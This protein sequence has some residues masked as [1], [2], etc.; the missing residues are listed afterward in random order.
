MSTPSLPDMSKLSNSALDFIDDVRF[1]ELLSKKSDAGRIR[2]I[3][4]KSKAKQALNLDEAAA[5]LNAD[6]PELVE[7]IYDTARQLKK[8][9]YGNRIVLFAPFYV[10]NLC[11]NDCQYC[12]FR[13]S[14]AEQIRH[15]LTVEELHEQVSRML[16]MGQKR[17]IAVFGEHR[18]Y[19]AQYIADTVREIYSV[20]Y[21]SPKT[22]SISSLRRVNINA[23][24]LDHG[25]YKIVREA[26]I[27]TYQVFQE[28][29]HKPTYRKMHPA[30]TRKSDFMWRLD[31]PARAIE[32][33]CDDVGLGALFGLASW[34]F[35]ALSLVAHAIHLMSNYNV[36]PHTI[37]FPRIR[38]ASGLHIQE[39]IDNNVADRD[40]LR[41]IA[42]LRLS[43]PYTGLIVTAR[44]PANVRQEALGFG[45]SQLDAG[46]RIEIGGYK[47]INSESVDAQ[48]QALNR[49]QFE[50][51]DV[52]SLDTVV[53]ELL[54]NGYIPS[55][56]TA[57]YR[58]GRTG[59]VF[60]E[61]A[62]PGFIQDFCTPNAL[63]TLQEYLQDFASPETK[64]VGE[65]LVEQEIAKLPDDRRKQM[66]V[67]RLEKIRS[68][69]KRDL[70]F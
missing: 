53:K 9:V 37:S 35:D 65:K 50:L 26:G 18:N 15:T 63:S 69:D 13:R 22:G 8:D 33:G 17:T 24:P 41:M 48:Q 56:C 55:F 57:C 62:K 34:K 3:A 21:R 14:N 58:L 20:K 36:G 23:A 6:E 64:A 59:E 32:S 43:V 60:M 31:S 16:A 54:E 39:V 67:Q 70:F 68:T 27:G 29:Y 19:G 42:V 61:Y 49:E 51:G 38:P 5:L 11:M 28:T 12:G 1:G 52:R 47:D 45:V 7:L 2:E 44:E 40:F 25:G 46:G 10:G 4:A 66:L 30:G